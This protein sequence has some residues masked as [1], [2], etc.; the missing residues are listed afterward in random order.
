MSEEN[1]CEICGKRFKSSQGLAGHVQLK[2]GGG[3]AQVKPRGGGGVIS[4]QLAELSQI[5]NWRYQMLVNRVLA[6]ELARMEQEFYHA[7]QG[8]QHSAQATAQRNVIV[9]PSAPQEPETLCPV[10]GGVIPMDYGDRRR[11]VQ[12]QREGVR[13]VYACPH[14]RSALSPSSF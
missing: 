1:V 11:T 13:G 5:A 14:C 6:L 12:A 8:A 3:S 2:H 7:Q 10:C 9:L 4:N